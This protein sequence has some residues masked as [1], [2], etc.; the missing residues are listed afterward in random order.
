MMELFIILIINFS[1]INSQI[2]ENPIFLNDKGYPFVLK[3]NDDYYYV[4]TKGQYITIKFSSF[5]IS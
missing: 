1:L 5:G 3:S 2:K 4:V